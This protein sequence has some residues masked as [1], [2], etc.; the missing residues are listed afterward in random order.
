MIDIILE[1]FPPNI[2]PKKING[3]NKNFQFIIATII[4]NK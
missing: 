1:T 3:F 2:Y 4:P